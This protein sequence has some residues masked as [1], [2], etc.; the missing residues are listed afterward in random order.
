MV[1]FGGWNGKD[2]YNDV[3]VLD[4][5]I[6]A[7]SKPETSGKSFNKLIIRTRSFPS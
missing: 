2:F 7:W 6:M 4:L 5:Q 3:Y 1:V